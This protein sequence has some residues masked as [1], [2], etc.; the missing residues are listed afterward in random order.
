[1]N[2]TVQTQ[3]RRAGRPPASEARSNDPQRTIANIIEVA[4][5][6]FAE[7]GLAG[8]RIDEIAALTHTSK[9]MIYYHFGSK[10]GLYIAV[11]EEAYRHI[12]AIEATLSLEDLE[13]EAALA[14]LVGFTYDHQLANPDFI[15]LVMS[16]NIQKGEFLAQSKSIQ[17]LNVPVINAV[18]AVYDRGVKTGV[19]RRGLDAV[20]LHMS[21]SALCFFNVANRHTFA[22][23]FKRD[24]T[25]AGEMT[26]RRRNI[27]DMVLRFV[28][29]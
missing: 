17:Q 7:K 8:G 11:L 15:R 9:R 10:E 6:E 27:I 26:S 1:M 25:D 28:R 5:R 12:R 23:I 16:E 29:K 4:T 13:P 18:K 20:D 3:R 19:F 21:I 24:M 2:E 14:K 22:L